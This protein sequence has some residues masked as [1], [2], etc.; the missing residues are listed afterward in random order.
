MSIRTQVIVSESLLDEGLSNKI[1][2]IQFDVA[3]DQQIFR[4]DKLEA[5]NLLYVL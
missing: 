5:E 4:S 2:D 3:E 1:Q